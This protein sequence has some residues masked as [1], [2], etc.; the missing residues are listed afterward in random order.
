VSEL[1]AAVAG[2]WAD[3]GR[4]R[5]LDAE[6]PMP[7]LLLEHQ[8]IW[9]LA[10]HRFGHWVHASDVRRA[11]PLRAMWFVWNKVVESSTG[12]TINPHAQIAPGLYIGHFGG[13]VVGGGV[14]IGARCAISQ[15]VTLGADLR[16][17]VHGSPALGERVYV[18]PG[19]VVAG[20][21]TVG[22]G[23]AIGANA[24]VRDDV[25]PGALAVGVPARVVR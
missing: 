17:G 19:A 22:D 2:W 13:I 15:G 24:V 8:G 12:I 3:V 23:A 6:T 20:P 21:L 7:L 11:W 5:E 4:W 9:A 25:P 1:R 14:R 10:C 16:D 18:A